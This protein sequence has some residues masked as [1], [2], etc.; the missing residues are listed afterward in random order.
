VSGHICSDRAMRT[1]PI[2]STTLVAL[3]F[4]W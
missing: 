4:G 3:G 1:S 2:R